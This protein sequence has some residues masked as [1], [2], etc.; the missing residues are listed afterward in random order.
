MS[1]IYACCV[2]LCNSSGL[3]S[4]PSFIFRQGD[5]GGAISYKKLYETA[6]PSKIVIATL[7]PWPNQI[8]NVILM[9]YLLLVSE[10][11]HISKAV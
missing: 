2:Q 10:C 1:R 8:P 5:S 6:K 3:N 4:V 9:F 11:E 7:F